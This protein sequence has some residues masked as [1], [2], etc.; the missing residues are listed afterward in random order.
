[1]GEDWPPLSLIIE[2]A[3]AEL[4]RPGDKGPDRLDA[5]TMMES[6]SLLESDYWERH[7]A[8]AKEWVDDVEIIE[9]FE[10]P[11]AKSVGSFDEIE[12]QEDGHRS[13]HYTRKSRAKSAMHGDKPLEQANKEGEV[14]DEAED[15]SEDDSEDELD[16]ELRLEMD[17]ET[18][19]P[20]RAENTEDEEPDDYSDY[21]EAG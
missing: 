2:L 7:E 17:R 19:A 3:V 5:L 1:M 16:V 11:K 4:D 14:D 18:W 12:E 9:I 10:R 8:K 13:F 6:G 21:E 15:D 20:G